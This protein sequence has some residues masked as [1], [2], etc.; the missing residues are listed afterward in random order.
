MRRTITIL[1]VSILLA[2]T[3]SFP[4]KKEDNHPRSPVFKDYK[5]EKP[6]ALLVQ[7]D[8]TYQ[9]W[10]T[11]M[12]E[13]QANAGD[14]LAQHEL[15]I[16]YLTGR[17]ASADTLKGAMWIGRAASQN[18]TPAKFNL[19]ILYY[20]GWGVE[21]NPFSAYRQFRVAAERGMTEA[22]YVLGQFLTDDL[23]VP[24]NIDEA[25]R[26]VKLAADSGYAP[27]QDAFKELQKQRA[28]R[29]QQDQHADSS[30]AL[31]LL[32][33]GGDSSAVQHET[34]LMRE[35]LETGGEELKKA[36][37]FANLLNEG[38]STDTVDVEAIRRAADD[39]S[40]EALAVLGRSQEK[41]TL[42]PRDLIGAAEMYIRAV[43]LDFPRAF[44]LLYNLVQGGDVLTR[45]KARS[46]AGE[47]RAQYV[48]A[49]LR[50]LRFDGQLYEAQIWISDEQAV[51]LLEK[52]SA[53][54]HAPSIVE[55]GLCHFSGRWVPVDANKAMELW[56]RAARLGSRDAQ[57][58]IA[59]TRVRSGVTGKALA[60][61]VETLADAI[62]QGSLLAQVA[63]GYCHETGVGV[64][65]SLAV[66]ARLYRRAA[67]RGSQDAYRALKRLHD[68]LRPDEAEFK[69]GG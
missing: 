3:V 69:V 53:A 16:R 66:A 37:G 2:R 48:W 19:G 47:P 1:V 10:Q 35:V 45:V 57:V 58:R 29:E 11:F 51:R 64:P 52:G 23:V 56:Q 7:S 24:R 38:S 44:E 63:L 14:M 30:S 61:S 18:L 40:P 55:L 22:R 21:W 36:L 49:S 32:D 20:H 17:G 9:L 65:Q 25:M 46:A 62:Q 34:M 39:G 67:Q 6:A 8:I 33:F 42:V 59:I 27:A 41:G 26:W 5:K 31:M 68:S 28:R 12:L 43:R 50:A 60:A 4:Q 54:N 13:R 15:G